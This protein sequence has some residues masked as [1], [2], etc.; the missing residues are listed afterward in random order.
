[1]ITKKLNI[2]EMIVPFKQIAVCSWDCEFFSEIL[3]LQSKA[4][5]IISLFINYEFFKKAR[6]LISSNLVDLL[7]IE[8]IILRDRFKY[9]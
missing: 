7:A 4:V 2:P 1:M 8:R 5:E 6:S 3:Y 9:L